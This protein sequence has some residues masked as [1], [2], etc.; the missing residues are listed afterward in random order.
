MDEDLSMGTPDLGHPVFVSFPGTQ[1]SR[2]QMQEGAWKRDERR[3]RWD[4]WVWWQTTRRGTLPS[5]VQ[6]QMR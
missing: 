2:Y 6:G 4:G 5:K 3:G 1:S